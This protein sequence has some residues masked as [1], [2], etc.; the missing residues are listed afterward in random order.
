MAPQT[1][2]EEALDV[3]RL[4][5]LVDDEAAG[6]ADLEAVYGIEPDDAWARDQVLG[7]FA[8][9]RRNDARAAL[10]ML[11]HDYK[12]R[13]EEGVAG[14]R[15]QSAAQVL[16]CDYNAPRTLSKYYQRRLLGVDAAGRV[17]LYQS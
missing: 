10:K 13:R 14:L 9:A 2:E 1:P 17:C 3:E 6:L 4:R 8:R 12:W 7:R 15:T 5:E 11:Q 16:G